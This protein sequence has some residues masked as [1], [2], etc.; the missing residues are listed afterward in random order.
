MG[1][2][3][4]AGGSGSGFLSTTA[5]L[6]VLAL[7]V[8]VAAALPTFRSALASHVRQTRQY[9]LGPDGDD[10]GARPGANT[11][12]DPEVSHGG[13][14]DGAPASPADRASDRERFEFDLDVFG[15][16]YGGHVH[17]PPQDG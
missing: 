3:L 5:P 16:L 11:P 14:L 2:N 8:V 12:G 6:L 7:L 1:I 15:D 9:F 13:A 10:D 4:S 17:G